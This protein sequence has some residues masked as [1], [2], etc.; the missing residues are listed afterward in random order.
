MSYSYHLHWTFKQR[1][2]QLRDAQ[3]R[4]APKHLEG[5]I[6]LS[7]HVAYVRRL[8]DGR[9]LYSLGDGGWNYARGPLEV[10][11]AF[12]VHLAAARLT[13]KP[14]TYERRAEACK[15]CPPCVALR[16]RRE[17]DDPPW[18]VDLFREA[19]D[20]PRSKG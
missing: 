8:V 3:V 2:A 6:R 14:T 20:R 17:K 18:Q 16:L 5:T 9:T 13:G 7:N 11:E 1:S 19:H 10:E 12:L 4:T 15:A